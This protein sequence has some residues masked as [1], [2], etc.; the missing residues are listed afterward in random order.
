MA[1]EAQKHG[2]TIERNSLRTERGIIEKRL[3][4][5]DVALADIAMSKCGLARGQVRRVSADAARVQEELKVGDL[6]YVDYCPEAPEDKVLLFLEPNVGYACS[7]VVASQM[8]K[9]PF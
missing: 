5:I 3:A 7:M 1:N 8:E 6:V 9:V 2:L 4:E